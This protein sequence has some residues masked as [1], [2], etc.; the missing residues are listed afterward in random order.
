MYVYDKRQFLII[1]NVMKVQRNKK[2][3]K[4]KTSTDKHHLLTY[5]LTCPNPL[6]NSNVNSYFEIMTSVLSRNY[7]SQ[8]L[9]I[10]TTD[11][12]TCKLCND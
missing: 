7:Y 9:F 2:V 10:L 3:C 6:I 8:V 4:K 11:L 1:A 5:L 12:L